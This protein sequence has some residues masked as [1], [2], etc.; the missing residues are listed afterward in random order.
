MFV[1]GLRK[2]G[3]SPNEAAK[4]L[5]QR[6]LDAGTLDNVSVIIVYFSW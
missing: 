4:R 1:E 5:V 3:A 6:V 2:S